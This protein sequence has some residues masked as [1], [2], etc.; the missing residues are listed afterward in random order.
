MNVRYLQRTKSDA[1]HL[2]CDTPYGQ[3]ATMHIVVSHFN[4]TFK[5]V[6]GSTTNDLQQGIHNEDERSLQWSKEVE[7]INEKTK[8]NIAP[9]TDQ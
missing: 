8:V 9:P 1:D 2:S 5:A 4:D 3:Y 7:S 6:E